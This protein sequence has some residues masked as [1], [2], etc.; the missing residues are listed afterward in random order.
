MIAGDLPSGREHFVGDRAHQALRGAAVDQAHAARGELAPERP[1]LLLDRGFGVRARAAVDADALQ[2]HGEQSTTPGTGCRASP[3]ERPAR[4]AGTR[5]RART[6][7]RAQQGPV[8]H[9]KSARRKP[10]V[11]DRSDRD[12]AAAGALDRRRGLA[13]RLARREDVLDDHDG[14]ARRERKAPPEREG[15]VLALDEHRGNP[16]T[17]AGLVPD[18]DA[19]ERRRDDG[20]GSKLAQ[21]L[22]ETPAR[23]LGAFR[24]HEKPGALKVPVGVEPAREAEVA[25]QQRPGLLEV[26]ERNHGADSTRAVEQPV[27]IPGTGGPTD[28]FPS[29]TGTPKGSLASLGMTNGQ[30]SPSREIL[31]CSIFL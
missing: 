15:A 3:G 11:H 9:G 29:R 10:P 21:L 22:R 20:P 6:A 2:V 24:P 16:E 26:L 23:P 25:G 19:P 13:R 8:R 31:W 7:R 1:D 14:L 17:P 28:P 5:P 4:T 30:A 27:V 12:D 18:D